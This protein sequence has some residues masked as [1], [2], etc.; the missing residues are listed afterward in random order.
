MLE[1]LL[2]VQFT[3][4]F[5][6]SIKFINTILIHMELRSVRVFSIKSFYEESFCYKTLQ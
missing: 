2:A 5:K 4:K 1:Q 3:D 6:I